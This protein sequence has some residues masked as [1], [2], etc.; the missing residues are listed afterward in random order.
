M[1]SFGRN[2][3][4]TT[5][6]CGR[7]LHQ[8]TRKL[9]LLPGSMMTSSDRPSRSFKAKLPILLDLR[10]GRDRPTFDRS[11]GQAAQLAIPPR[12]HQGCRSHSLFLEKSD[13]FN[14]LLLDF[15]AV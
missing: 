13:L 3:S 4:T 11:Q 5:L 9:Y 1:I 6:R 8:Q 15:T 7:Q 10:Q 2:F 12:D 14:R